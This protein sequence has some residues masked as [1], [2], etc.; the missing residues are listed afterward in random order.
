MTAARIRARRIAAQA[1]G[2]TLLEALVAVALIGF[3]CT[4]LATVTAQWLPNWKKGFA[5]VQRNELLGLALDR[6]AADF[7]AAE[8]V[9]PNGQTNKV[10]F[11]GSR[12]SATF[13]RA[14]IGP[15]ADAGLEIVRFSARD[16]D[17]GLARARA[18]FRPIGTASADAFEFSDEIALIRDPLKISFSFA[19]RDRTWR[20]TWR[21]SQQ[22][23]TAVRLTLRD[24]AS[25]EILAVS[26]A[27][28]LHVT[29]PAE[30]VRANSAFGC[31]QQLERADGGRQP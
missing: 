9:T 8:F 6:A 1:Q 27:T 20:E 26:T 4:I 2:F 12:T 13:V 17:L 10:L 15:N 11:E 25:D 16:D 29:G 24:G 22:L 18:P 3:I 23:P 30:C 19:G 31:I 28:L 7:A 21:D 5:R 14:A